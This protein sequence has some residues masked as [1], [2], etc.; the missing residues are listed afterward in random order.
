MSF[1]GNWLAFLENAFQI[2]VFHLNDYELYVPKFVKK[3]V[4]DPSKQ[5]Q[6]T[7][8]SS[9]GKKKTPTLWSCDV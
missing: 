1:N 7:G 8:K 6:Q 5:Q 2:S 4:I 3:V 9:N